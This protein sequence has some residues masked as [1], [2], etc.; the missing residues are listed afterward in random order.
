MAVD[1]NP[2]SG[3]G[4]EEKLHDA[5]TRVEEDLK[6]VI[7]YIND[8][9]VPEVRKNGSAALRVAAEQLEK[10]AQKMEERAG[11][12]PKGGTK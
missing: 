8:E 7:A 1:P 5:G 11:R 6:R 9:V 2:K 3:P 12:P 4:W 10:L